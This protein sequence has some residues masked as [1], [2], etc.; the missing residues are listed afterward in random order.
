MLDAPDRDHLFVSHAPSDW[1]L[2]E[3]LTLRLATEGYR[4][5]CSRFPML[6]GERF[7]RDVSAAIRERVFRV[8]ALLSR[9]SLSTPADGNARELAL[10]V[11]GERHV[12]FLIG[13]TVDDPDSM[14]PDPALR[15]LPC[16]PFHERWETGFVGLVAMLRALEAPRPLVNGAEVAVEAR[17]FLSSRRSWHT[18]L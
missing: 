11:A 14:A 18:V 8:L 1:A 12:D 5:W 16:V 10:A 15:H 3:W 7:P 4:V 6:G 17:Q 9:A 2:A 13:L